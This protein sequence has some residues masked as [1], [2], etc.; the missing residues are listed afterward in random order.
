MRKHVLSS[1]LIVCIFALKPQIGLTQDAVYCREIDSILKARNIPFPFGV[2]SGDP[3]YTSVV[4]W[5]A[6]YTNQSG[7][8]PVEWEMADDSM[9]TQ[10]LLNGEIVARPENGYSV[11]VMVE[12]LSEGQVYFY[13]FRFNKS[14]SPI[15]RTRTAARQSDRL[16]F[17]VVSCSSFSWGYFNAYA[18]LA[19]EPNL[20]AV[21]HLGDYIYEYGPEK[22][23]N[24]KLKR[25]HLPKHEIVTLQD[26]RSRYAQYRIDAD[27]QEVHRLHPFISIW[28]DHEIANDAYK[29]GAQNHQPETEGDWNI[30]NS[31]ARKAYFEWMPLADNAGL[32][33]RRALSFGNLADLYML[34]GRLEGR[35]KQAN[36]PNDVVL[37]DTSR[38]MLGKEQAD[39]L[40]ESVSNSDAVWKLIGNQVVFSEYSV[41]AKMGNYGKTTDMW[42]GYP[43]ERNRILQSWKN[44]GVNDV[45]ILTGDMHCSFAIDLRYRRND[46]SSSF[47]AEWVTTSVTSSNLDEY[48]KRWK[49]RI[50]EYLFKKKKYNP[51]LTYCNLRDHGYLRVDID[52]EKAIAGWKY[53][54]IL[55]P[56]RAKSRLAK[57]VVKTVNKS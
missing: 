32:S 17:G 54:E 33:I 14:Y 15:G 12:N 56:N 23:G 27:L 55:K 8:M 44:K 43:A 39:W 47:G 35:S 53:V 46:A 48:S 25:G 18:A 3:R 57:R 41:P 20:Q 4:L 31:T 28:D 7:N 2:A 42:N 1:I 13:R 22:Y 34:D 29:E 21:I 6:I 9:F 10:P 24:T 11:K 19:K 16:S 51:H 26:Y 49:I 36:S 37:S 30:R 38:S 45:L 50:A 52:R 5:T 40:I